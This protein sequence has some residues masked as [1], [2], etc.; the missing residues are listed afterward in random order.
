MKKKKKKKK[1]PLSVKVCDLDS[2]IPEAV[3]LTCS[4]SESKEKNLI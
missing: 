1:G 4:T 3:F 2:S